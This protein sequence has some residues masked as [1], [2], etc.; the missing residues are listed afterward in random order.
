MHKTIAP[1][2]R[3]CLLAL[4]L[5]VPAVSISAE[6]PAAA[7]PAASVSPAEQKKPDVSN[8]ERPVKIGYVDL[9]RLGSETEAG[10]AARE[11]VRKKSERLENQVTTRQRQLEKQKA[12]LQVKLPSLPAKEQEAR[13]REFEKKVDEHRKYLQNVEKEM[14]G[15]ETE[16]T[17]QLYQ[18]IEEAA[19]TFGKANGYAAIVVKRELLYVGSDVEGEDVTTAVLKLMNPRREKK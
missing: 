14:K 5:A 9:T 4:L 16:V 12:A 2:P 7:L 17:R 19:S 3:F 11:K 1:F 8:T 10:K 15:F 6:M 18:D 13:A